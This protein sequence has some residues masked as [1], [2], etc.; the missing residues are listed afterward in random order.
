MNNMKDIYM[1]SVLLMGFIFL[2]L[3]SRSQENKNALELPALFAENMVLQQNSQ[4]PIWGWANP[5]TKIIIKASWDSQLIIETKTDENGDWK[6][7]IPT[8]YAGGPFVLSINHLK[9]ENV[10][11]GEVWICSGQSNMQWALDQSLNGEEE[12]E[13]SENPNIRLF[14][15][16]RQVSDEPL[17]DCHAYWTESNPET[18][19]DFSA[20]A[21]YFGKKLQ[22]ELGIP[23]GL[24]HTSWGGS[25]A[26]AWVKEDVLK[27]DP[28]YQFYYNQ[29]IANEKKA[30]RGGLALT[31]NSPNA[32]YNA[33]IA[34]LTPFAIKGAIWY[35]GEANVDEAKLYEKL[36]PTMIRSWRDEWA[37]GAFPFYYV[38]LAP[39]Q[40]SSKYVGALLRDAQRKTLSLE[41]TGMAIT[42]DIGNPVDIH[43]TNKIDVGNRLAAWALVKDYGKD[44]ELYCG[45]LYKKM[46]KEGEKIRLHFNF[47]KGGLKID[48]DKIINMEIAGVDKMFVPAQSIIDGE[49][50][51]VWSESIKSPIAV[52]YAF[53]NTDASNL[54]NKARLPASSFRTDDW[55]IITEKAKINSCFDNATKTI[56]ISMESQKDYEIFYTLD[57]ADPDLNSLKYEKSFIMENAGVIKAR[58]FV[59]G[60]ASVEVSSFEIVDNMA[61]GKPLK[62]LNKYVARYSGG[63]D[64]ALVN[65]M[66]AGYEYN[67]GAWQGFQKTDIEIII[68]LE[69]VETI[70]SLKAGF[71]QVQGS[72][73]LFPKEVEYYVSTDG[74]DYKLL[75]KVESKISNKKDGKLIQDFSLNTKTNARF[76]KVKVAQQKLPDWHVSAG[77]DAWHFMDEIIVE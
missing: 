65:C 8:P 33:M 57:G 10:L 34:P 50:I 63:G 1:R 17:K 59:D 38:Q 11:I 22:E 25:P 72:W 44:D 37:Q 29:Q 64:Q 16:A 58:V 14:Y 41:N 54:F 43:P 60:Q 47:A 4:A 13:K 36:F 53:H 2:V 19:K 23:I 46:E 40:Y 62:Y 75:G 5:G 73:I 48:G 21:Y 49:T 20:V 55:P 51:L 12:I 15:L 68:D 70:N 6:T 31:H 67:D 52:R 24:I 18:A 26:E 32:L 69:K 9:I 39:F 3:I 76:I 71:L 77:Q 74:I 7:E 66:R 27:A 28:D 42:M 45:P 30:K 61:K 56:G 35:Q